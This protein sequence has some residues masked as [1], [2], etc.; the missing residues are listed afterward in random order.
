MATIASKPDLTAVNHDCGVKFIWTEP[1]GGG[2]NIT[3]YN[4]ELRQNDQKPFKKVYIHECGLD[5]NKLSCW[6]DSDELSHIPF[7]IEGGTTF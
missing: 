6:V 7:E 2:V 5:P 3:G 1:D 4:L